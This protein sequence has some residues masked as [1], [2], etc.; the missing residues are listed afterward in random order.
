M[1]SLAGVT[2]AAGTAA[3][4][5]AVHARMPLVVVLSGF[6]L[7]QSAQT[8]ARPAWSALIPRIVGEQHAAAM[9]GTQQTLSFLTR[10]AGPDQVWARIEL[11]LPP[12]RGRGRPFPRSPAGGGGHRL[13][14]SGRDLVA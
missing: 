12:L 14:V 5:V 7:V 13:P 6:L 9:S 4:A 11:L 3:M 2:A 10:L 8:V 1:T